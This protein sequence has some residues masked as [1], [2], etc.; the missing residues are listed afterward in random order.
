M[1]FDINLDGFAHYGLLPDYLHDVRNIGVTANEMAP[2][3]RSAEDYIVMWETIE[4]KRPA[5]ISAR[6]AL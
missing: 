5:V 2:L 6:D 4:A 3:F 1:D